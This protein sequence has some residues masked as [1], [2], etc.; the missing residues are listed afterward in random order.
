M[1]RRLPRLSRQQY[2]NWDLTD[3]DG[4]SIEGVRLIHDDIAARVRALLASLAVIEAV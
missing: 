1:R 3:P 2:Q 4:L